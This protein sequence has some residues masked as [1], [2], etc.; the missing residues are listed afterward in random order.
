MSALWSRSASPG[1]QNDLTRMRCRR[2]RGIWTAGAWEWQAIERGLWLLDTLITPEAWQLATCGPRS[3]C[4]KRSEDE[5]SLSV[6]P[7]T[8]N[9][10]KMSTANNRRIER[11]GNRAIHPAAPSSHASFPLEPIQDA[12]TDT[13]NDDNTAQQGPSHASLPAEPTQSADVDSVN[14]ENAPLPTA[15]PSAQISTPPD[16]S[17]VKRGMGWASV[18]SQDP[19]RHSCDVRSTRLRSQRTSRL[20]RYY[21]GAVARNQQDYEQLATELDA[22]SKSLLRTCKEVAPGS[23]ADCVTGIAKYVDRLAVSLS[24]ANSSAGLET[25]ADGERGRAGSDE[26]VQADTVAVSAAAD[27][28]RD[29]HLGKHERTGVKA[30]GTERGEKGNIRLTALGTDQ[31][32]DMHRRHAGQSTRRTQ[33]WVIEAAG[34]S[35]Y[36]MSGM[37]GTGKTTIACTFAKWLEAE[38][39]LAASFFCT[40]TSADCQD[41]TRIIPTVAYQLARYSIPFRSALCD[42]LGN[43]SDIGSKDIAAQFEKL[44]L[45]PLNRMKD[46]TPDGMCRDL[47]NDG[48]ARSVSRG[49]TPAQD[50]GVAGQR[51]HQAVPGRGACANIASASDIE[52][53]VRRSGA[54]HLCATLFRYIYLP[55][56]GYSQKRLDI[57]NGSGD[58][59]RDT[60]RLTLYKA[61]LSRAGRQRDGRGREGRRP[62]GTTYVLLAQEPIGIQTIATLGAVGDTSRVEYAL[63]SLS[64]VLYESGT[65]AIW[66]LLL[67]HIEAQSTGD[68]AM[69]RGCQEPERA[70]RIEHLTPARIC[71]PLLGKPPSASAGGRRN[72]GGTG[73]VCIDATA[74]LDGGAER[75]GDL[76][77]GAGT[78]QLMNAKQWLMSFGPTVSVNA[79]VN[80]EDAINFVAGTSSPPLPAPDAR[81]GGAEGQSDGPQRDSRT[82][83]LEH[84]SPVFSWR[85]QGMAVKLQSDADGTVSIRNA[86]DGTLL[87]GPWNAHTMFVLW[88]V[89]TGTPVA[90]PFRGHTDLVFSVSFSPDSKRIVSGSGDKTVCIWDTADGTLLVGPLH[91]HTGSVLSVAYSPDG[92][93]IASASHDNTIRLWRSDDGT[94]AASPLQGHTR[95][96]NSVAFTPDGT[97]LVSGSSDKTVRV[98]RVSDGSAVATP[99]QGHSGRVYSVAV[100][101]M[102]C[103]LHLGLDVLCECGG[104]AM[105]GYSPMGRESSLALMMDRSCLEC[106]RRHDVPASS[107]CRVRERRMW[108]VSSGISQPAS[109]NI[110]VPHPIYAASP[111]RSYTAETNTDG[112]LV[113][114]VRT[115]DKSVAAGPFDRTP[116]VWQFSQDSTCTGQT[117]FQLRSTDD[118]W[119]D[120]IAEC[121]D[122]SLLASSHNRTFAT[123]STSPLRIWSMAGP[124]LCFRS[125]DNTPLNLEPD[126]PLSELYDQCHIN[127]DGWMVNSSNHLLLWLPSQIADAG[128]S[129]FVSVIVT[130]SG[131][132][133]VPKQM[134]LVG[135]EWDKCYV[136]G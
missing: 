11:K 46:D 135:P 48:G 94:P 132:L 84:S 78:V 53:L 61:V 100:S 15:R 27:E 49:Y 60:R 34:Q 109:P 33:S 7:T 98:W 91:G 108:D 129:P 51:G 118:D 125:S 42:I 9:N 6:Y 88:D 41:V 13:P 103:L 95:S 96:V 77:T 10:R 55:A 119:V 25:G 99:F 104:S 105:V 30:W 57:M 50:R 128:L 101:L 3:L 87:V 40:R 116:R 102:A 131:T 115:D 130:T 82:G 117:A 8:T 66:D 52:E 107:E 63:R 136:R 65:E 56:E 31:P 72:A 5:R 74:V 114:V 18:D 133:Q 69:L 64:S 97:R 124:T 26:A 24:T 76:S 32:T 47:R 59:S 80:T 1:F 22:L 89:R 127:G 14:D 35:V 134:L 73:R 12:H 20:L 19:E 123:F 120:L 70:D 16:T 21:R 93:L 75:A 71:M 79:G 29:E 17:G 92:T 106:A 112:E 121:P 36:W 67:R 126:Q 58:V 28:H 111:D 90:G 44:I 81:A 23:A 38:K 86:Y 54:V 2:L 37:A 110:Q 43:D 83:H 85:T 4:Y 113:Q 68:A 62:G 39:L 122:R 45:D